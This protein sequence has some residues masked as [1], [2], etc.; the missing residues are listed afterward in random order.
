MSLLLDEDKF[1]LGDSVH[2]VGVQDELKRPLG[3]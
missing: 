2:A 1:V 3:Q